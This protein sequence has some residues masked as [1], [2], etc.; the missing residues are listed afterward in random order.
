MSQREALSNKALP[1]QTSTSPIPPL[2]TS[3]RLLR[4]P[5]NPSPEAPALLPSAIPN[6]SPET[7]LSRSQQF[8]QL[9]TE[10]IP[11]PVINK[12]IRIATIASVYVIS[13]LSQP[14]L[15]AHAQS[16]DLC[17][18]L[19]ATCIIKDDQLVIQ[20]DTDTSI[21][22]TDFF[23]YLDLRSGCFGWHLD[24][25]FPAE[26]MDNFQTELGATIEA[27]VDVNNQVILPNI[28]DN[29]EPVY[30]PLDDFTQAIDTILED[31]D[32]PTQS[33]PISPPETM[34]ESPAEPLPAIPEAESPAQ[35]PSAIPDE[36]NPLPPESS[37][38][39][40]TF[41]ENLSIAQRYILLCLG[42]PTLFL[43]TLFVFKFLSSGE[44][45][46]RR[47]T[48]DIR[49]VARECQKEAKVINRWDRE[50]EVESLGWIKYIWQMF[51][52]PKEG[53]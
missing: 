31:S 29:Q 3:L 4:P 41:I 26:K 32:A 5:S 18:S 20:F 50:A 25:P 13:L 28:C 34:P 12:S 11:W 51:F 15:I 49:R 43:G 19:V 14:N 7:S 45:S 2:I 22:I 46:K 44:K 40:T 8:R 24:S 10:L 42:L 23:H 16:E 38:N 27:Q 37:S 1:I 30:I 9:I 35:S 36:S 48:R 47:Q 53:K 39:P 33:A 21:D 17:D 52:P 6:P